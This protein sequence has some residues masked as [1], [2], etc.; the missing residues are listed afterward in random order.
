[1]QMTFWGAFFTSSVDFSLHY[2]ETHLCPE[3]MQILFIVSRSDLLHARMNK[4][5]KKYKEILEKDNLN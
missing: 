2:A 1:M 4:V 3:K 5:L